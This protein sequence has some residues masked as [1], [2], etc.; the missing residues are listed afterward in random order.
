MPGFSVLLNEKHLVTIAT[1]QLNV[2]SVRVHGD[3]VSPELAD[4]QIDGGI[5]GDAINTKHLIWLSEQEIVEGD[6]VTVNFHE[7]VE[8]FDRGKTVDELYP[9]KDR[10]SRGSESVEDIFREIALM[11]KTRESFSFDL[12]T[13]SGEKIRAKTEPEDHGFGFTVLWNWLHPDVAMVSLTSHSLAGVLNQENGSE[14]AK[15]TLRYG[16][17]TSFSVSE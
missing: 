7:H 12:E 16:Q 3:C 1:D 10:G 13:A 17:K 5:Y 8:N 15:F 11:P 6:E 2:V 9:N 4:L 14:Y